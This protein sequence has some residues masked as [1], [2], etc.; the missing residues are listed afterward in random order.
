MKQSTKD[1]IQEAV[2]DLKDMGG[3]SDPNVKK[4]IKKLK[5][6]LKDEEKSKK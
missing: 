3:L 6:A 5:K 1:K 2:D 4:V